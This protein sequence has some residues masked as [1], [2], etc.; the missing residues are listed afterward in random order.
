[1]FVQQLALMLSKDRA[2]RPITTA[3]CLQYFAH[4]FGN[5]PKWLMMLVMALQM[6]S[7][8]IGDSHSAH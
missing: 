4:E 6:R 7:L 8:V 5:E 3:I 1:M 2:D